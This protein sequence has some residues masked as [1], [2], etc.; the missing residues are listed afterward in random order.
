ML[1]KLF[2]EYFIRTTSISHLTNSV[3]RKLC[4]CFCIYT[5]FSSSFKQAQSSLEA[6]SKKLDLLRKSLELRVQELPPNSRL[7]EQLR[8]ELQ[9]VP[10][11]APVHYTSLQPFREGSDGNKLVSSSSSLGRSALVTGKLKK[12]YVNF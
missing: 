8:K 5:H 6:S 4:K 11:S 3:S 10:Q 2:S 12:K 9:T 1:T 7:A